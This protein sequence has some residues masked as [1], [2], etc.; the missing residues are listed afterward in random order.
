MYRH[1]ITFGLLVSLSSF[2]ISSIKIRQQQSVSLVFNFELK[3]LYLFEIHS[4]VTF[5]H[6][7]AVNYILFPCYP[8][9]SFLIDDIYSTHTKSIAPTSGAIL[10]GIA[11]SFFFGGILTIVIVADCGVFIIDINNFCEIKRSFEENTSF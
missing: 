3:T 8:F 4:H 9:P 2:N 1:H 5:S 7:Y 6:V 10:S 11:Q